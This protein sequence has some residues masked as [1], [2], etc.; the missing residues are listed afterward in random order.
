MVD[1]PADPICH[2]EF[3][4]SDEKYP[5][6]G[7]PIFTLEQAYAALDRATVA[8]SNPPEG[9]EPAAWA[10][11][12]FRKAEGQKLQVGQ[13]DAGWLLILYHTATTATRISIGARPRLPRIVFFLPEWTDL[14]GSH[15]VPAE[16]GREALRVWLAGGDPAT[17]VPFEA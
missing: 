11:V 7:E 15:V 10:T 2:V 17:V 16:R 1:R 4:C 8:D 14:E 6:T 12:V 9:Q 13:S 5:E 3:P